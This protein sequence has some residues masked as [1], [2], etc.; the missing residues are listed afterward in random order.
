MVSLEAT[1]TELQ[2]LLTKTASRQDGNVQRSPDQSPPRG[3]MWQEMLRWGAEETQLKTCPDAAVGVPNQPPTVTGGSRPERMGSEEEERH[4]CRLF[5]TPGSGVLC[6]PT[7]TDHFVTYRPGE[8]R[9]FPLPWS[10]PHR[11]VALAILRSGSSDV[12]AGFYLG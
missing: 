8:C 9:P 12:L 4:H 2:D 11:D 10:L 5:I 1:P 3:H 6:L 7:C